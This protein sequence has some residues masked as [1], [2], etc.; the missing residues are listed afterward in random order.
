MGESSPSQAFDGM[1]MSGLPTS[2][3]SLPDQET[4]YGNHFSYDTRQRPVRVVVAGA[5]PS[6][7]ALAIALSNLPDVTFKV[8]DKNPEVSGT[9]YE[10]KY[11][12]AACDVASHAYQYTFASNHDWSSQWVHALNCIQ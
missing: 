9:W 5:G 2:I 1:G 12:G 3:G 6:G 4:L 11:L 10:N 8:F 7:I